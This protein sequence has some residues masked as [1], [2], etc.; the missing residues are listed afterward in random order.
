MRNVKLL[1]NRIY[2]EH[3]HSAAITDRAITALVL[4]IV[5]EQGFYDYERD[6]NSGVLRITAK[7]ELTRDDLNCL[8][9][10]SPNT[11]PRKG[12]VASII[13]Y[14]VAKAVARTESSK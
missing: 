3:M 9:I 6:P 14:I 5:A 12:V 11:K 8:C 1:L 7:A 4:M 2:A 13:H 10:L